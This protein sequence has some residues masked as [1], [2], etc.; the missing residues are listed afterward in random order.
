MIYL[1]GGPPKCGKSTDARRL[2]HHTGAAWLPLDSV[3]SVIY[4]YLPPDAPTPSGRRS[5]SS[6]TLPWLRTA[7]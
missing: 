3:E 4:H 6:S 5:R 2:A 7:T 1:I